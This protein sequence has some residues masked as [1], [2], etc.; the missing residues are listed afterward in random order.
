MSCCGNKRRKLRQTT[1]S[2]RDLGNSSRISAETK[3][4]D[5]TLVNFQYIGKSKL[6]VI[7]PRTRKLYR[8]NQ[9]GALVAVD[10]RDQVALSYVPTLRKVT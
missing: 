2:N 3:T 8:F 7:G 5:D 10:P 6:R 1:S 4:K 9:P